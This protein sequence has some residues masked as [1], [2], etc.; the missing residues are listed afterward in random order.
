MY[1]ADRWVVAFFEKVGYVG[2]ISII[3]YTFVIL[4]IGTLIGAAF[5]NRSHKKQFENSGDKDNTH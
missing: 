3:F 4:L 1:L 5:N 2:I